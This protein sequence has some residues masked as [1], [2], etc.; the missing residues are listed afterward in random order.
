MIYYQLPM[1]RNFLKMLF[2][3]LRKAIL[4][5]SLKCEAAFSKTV[6]ENERRVDIA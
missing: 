4:G 2:A 5:N 3:G 6:I 1:K